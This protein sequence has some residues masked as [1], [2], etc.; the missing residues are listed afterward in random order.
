[1]P[2]FLPTGQGADIAFSL[3]AVPALFACFLMLFSGLIDPIIIPAVYCL[4]AGAFNGFF[5]AMIFHNL[6]RLIPIE[7]DIY[8]TFSVLS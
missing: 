6:P 2:C 4:S 3:G 1:M 8:L 7:L 5:K